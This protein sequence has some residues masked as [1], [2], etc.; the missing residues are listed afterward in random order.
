M[1]DQRG[2]EGY[3]IG[4]ALEH[5]QCFRVVENQRKE[6]LLSNTVEFLHAYRAQPKI[7]PEDR[8]LH[9]IHFIYSA[10][11]DVPSTLFNYQLSAIDSIC[12]IVSKCSTNENTHIT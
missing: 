9:A 10:L 5:Y 4:P 8:I 12:N 6:L 3:T 1:W 7:T 2:Q 11:K